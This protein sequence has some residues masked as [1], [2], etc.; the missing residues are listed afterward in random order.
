[1]VLLLPRMLGAASFVFLK[2]NT[3]FTPLFSLMGTQRSYYNC[4]IYVTYNKLQNFTFNSI[5][6]LQ[7]QTQMLLIKE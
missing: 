1:M 2:T 6:V 3:L 7:L 5:I 4:I